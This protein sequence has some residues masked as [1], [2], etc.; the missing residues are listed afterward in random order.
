[1]YIKIKK[2]LFHV[3]SYHSRRFS[4]IF[5]PIHIIVKAIEMKF[6]MIQAIVLCY[7]KL[8]LAAK[9]CLSGNNIIKNRRTVFNFG[10]SKT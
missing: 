10:S 3:F 5:S 1:M 8:A 2:C 9:K 6:L 4:H 7:K